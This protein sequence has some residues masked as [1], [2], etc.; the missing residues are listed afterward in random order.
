MRRIRL[1]PSLS[2]FGDLSFASCGITEK[3]AKSGIT[4]GI[5]AENLDITMDSETDSLKGVLDLVERLD[6]LIAACIRSL[7][8]QVSQVVTV[9]Q[10]EI[11]KSVLVI[12][13][14]YDP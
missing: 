11:L 5:R 12:G 6:D 2:G 4:L 8:D 3:Q 7:S 13:S 10:W 1:P 14:Y 9:E